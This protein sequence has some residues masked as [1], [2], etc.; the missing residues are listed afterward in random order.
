MPEGKQ[1]GW[2]F[3]NFAGRATISDENGNRV[4]GDIVSID[5]VRYAKLTSK[6]GDLTIGYNG[7][8]G[9]WAFEENGGAVMV[10]YSVSPEGELYLAG[11]YEK[12]LL[13]NGGSIMFG[14]PGG[15]GITSESAEDT[16]KREVLEETGVHVSTMVSI[17]FSTPNRAFWI[18]NSDGNW[19]VTFYACRVDWSSLVEKDNQLY[20]PST[21]KAIA[22]L[23][24]LST[25]IFIPAIDAISNTNDG[26]AVTAYAKT[27]AAWQKKII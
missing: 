20:L 24:K 21:K 23:D 6:F 8:Y 7:V 1:L 9:Q 5:D 27:W 15:F 16:A 13:I 3:V 11:G 4:S 14:P 26:I 19:P 10:L 22:E 2:N 25:L 18:K 17:G 12:R